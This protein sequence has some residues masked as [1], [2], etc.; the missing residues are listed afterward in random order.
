MTSEDILQFCG[1]SA[2]QTEL[3]LESKS[4]QLVL[5]SAFLIQSVLEKLPFSTDGRAVYLHSYSAWM[6]QVR[7][8]ELKCLLDADP[9][10][11]RLLC[12]GPLLEQTLDK[13]RI[14][15]PD[16]DLYI[17]VGRHLVQIMDA[18]TNPTDIVSPETMQR[19][20]DLAPNTEICYVKIA[21]Y[22]RLLA[23]KNPALKIL[24]LGTSTSSGSIAKKIL[25]ALDSSDSIVI[26]QEYI[27][28]WQKYT[29]T[30][31]SPELLHTTKER[32]DRWSNHLSHAAFDPMKD[33]IQQG[34]AYQEYDLLISSQALSAN[35]VTCL[36]NLR[37]VLKPSGKLVLVEQTNPENIMMPFISGLCPD[38]WPT[39]A[40]GHSTRR[41]QI[42]SHEDW[43]DTLATNG[44]SGV[45]VR[46]PDFEDP[47]LHAYGAI[48]SSPAPDPNV[49]A[50]KPRTTV[51][52]VDKGSQKQSELASQ[53]RQNLGI[54]EMQDTKIKI[55]EEFRPNDLNQTSCI[56]LSRAR[57]TIHVRHESSRVQCAEGYDLD[58]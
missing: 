24:E 47:V 35:R 14:S 1:S 6:Q 46:L 22:I 55:I 39:Q 31:L 12:G 43:N 44:F 50:N 3:F 28:K 13:M 41:D 40:N 19:G 32:L 11:Q 10:G 57:K 29:C 15:N 38:W 27:T 2:P 51:I 4:R 36:Q 17:R 53:I 16:C 34:F 30:N 25:H 37:K 45:D 7:I 9:Q 8:S 23:N 54:N 48:I 56:F 33:I 5:I 18:Q 42:L 58:C 49:S 26:S 20:C 21:D 52:V